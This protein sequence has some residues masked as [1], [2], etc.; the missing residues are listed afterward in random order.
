MVLL[1]EDGALDGREHR[2]GLL[3]RR[4]HRQRDLDGELALVNLG[5]QLA[6]EPPHDLPRTGEAQP[7]DQEDQE[8]MGQGPFQDGGVGAAERGHQSVGD[9]A[10]EPQDHPEELA[11]AR[12][13]QT[14]RGRRAT[15]ESA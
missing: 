7:H 6:V 14:T 11:A 1:L 8:R 9:L 2:L 12:F 4:A 5:K 10:G 15:R 3:E 13:L